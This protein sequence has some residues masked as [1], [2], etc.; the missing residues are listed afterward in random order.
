MSERDLDRTLGFT[1]LL[2]AGRLAGLTQAEG[3]S[4]TT[5]FIQDY[6]L[7]RSGGLF[8]K[9]MLEYARDWRPSCDPR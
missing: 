7:E 6:W 9:T 5:R 8:R 4:L 3:E 1:A 2:E